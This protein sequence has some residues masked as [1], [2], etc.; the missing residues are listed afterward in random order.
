MNYVFLDIN[1]ILKH[2]SQNPNI[3]QVK[4]Q[5]ELLTAYVRTIETNTAPTTSSDRL[6]M[7]NFRMVINNKIVPQLNYQI[8]TQLLKDKLSDLS[9]NIRK[10]SSERNRILHFAL[11]INE[12]NPHSYDFSMPALD[13]PATYPTQIAKDCADSSD[14]HEISTDIAA[15]LQL[16]GASQ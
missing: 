14:S 4:S 1:F 8:E 10:L 3:D 13:A 16:K 9:K 2:L 6:F 7:A 5:L 15:T 11:N 12:V